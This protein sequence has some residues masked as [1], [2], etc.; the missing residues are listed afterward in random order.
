[1]R[2]T[3]HEMKWM[4][5]YASCFDTHRCETLSPQRSPHNEAA[6]LRKHIKDRDNA[7]ACVLRLKEKFESLVETRNVARQ[8]ISLEITK[9][10][11]IVSCVS[12]IFWREQRGILECKRNADIR[13]FSS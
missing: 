5:L 1:M 11:D 10:Q 12:R 3:I 6:V 4:L 9:F 2:S 7:Q 8:N 13:V